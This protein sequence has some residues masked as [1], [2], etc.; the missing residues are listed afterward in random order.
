MIGAIFG[1]GFFREWDS[2]RRLKLARM[3]LPEAED[4][5]AAILAATLFL[6]LRQFAAPGA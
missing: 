1:V 3:A 5:P 2:E 6:V 4:I